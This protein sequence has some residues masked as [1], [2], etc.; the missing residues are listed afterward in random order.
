MAWEGEVKQE[1]V[2][3]SEE[4]ESLKA[5]IASMSDQIAQLQTELNH[6]RNPKKGFF[7]RFFG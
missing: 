3:V 1:L 5:Q 6:L 7:S 4:N 2:D